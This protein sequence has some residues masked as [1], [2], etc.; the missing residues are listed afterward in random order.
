MRI[1]IGY[2]A[3]PLAS[4]RPLYIGGI[5]IPS[6]YGSV[7]HS[8]GD[9]LI[10][11]LCDALLG[12]AALGDIGKF[13]PSN[14]KQF[15]D[16]RSTILLSKVISRLKEQKFAVSNIDATIIL[17][18]PHI[19]EFTEP[20]RKLIATIVDIGLDRISIKATTTDGLGYIGKS[21]GIAA[22]VVVLLK[23]NV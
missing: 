10:H 14:D 5:K 6:A 18:K 15:K 21:E 8:D 4:G 13:F 12:A 7:G 3:H 19:S 9:V 2:D 22:Q 17:E 11:S 23:E 20:M 1:G 16:I